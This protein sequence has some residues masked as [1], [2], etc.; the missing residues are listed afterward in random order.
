VHEE[1]A[2]KRFL[3]ATDRVGPRRWCWVAVHPDLDHF[4]AAANRTAPH[5]GLAFWD[6][7]L[8]CF[9]PAIYRER[10][11][12]GEWI[13]RWPANGY[14]G[15]LRLIEGHV[16]SEIVAHELVH[17]AAQIYR[18]NVRQGIRLGEDCGEREEQ[19]AYVYGGLSGSLAAHNDFP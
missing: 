11:V 15:V 2:M 18:M 14:A 8:G 17:A 10:H 3:I 6:G 13:G 19:F 1:A 5:H 7:C 9:Q 4:R 16:T 12:D